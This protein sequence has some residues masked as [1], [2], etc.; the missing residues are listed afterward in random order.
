MFP[1]FLAHSQVLPASLLFTGSGSALPVQCLL[2]LLLCRV[3]LWGAALPTNTPNVPCILDAQARVGVCG[4]WLTGASLQSA[5]L[6]GWVLAD[7]LAAL[8]GVQGSAAA[9]LGLGLTE[10]FKPLREAE[11]GEFP[12]LP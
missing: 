1:S 11:I 10:P 8:R 4:D 9:G 3:Q 7:R 6:S 2:L 12:G 5:V